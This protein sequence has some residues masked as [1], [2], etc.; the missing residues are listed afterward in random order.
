M[1]QIKVRLEYTFG[2]VDKLTYDGRMLVE[3][4]ESGGNGFPPGTR[5]NIFQIADGRLA[6]WADGETREALWFD[7]FE[8]MEDMRKHVPG[9]IFSAAKEQQVWS[10]AQEQKGR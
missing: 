7:V 2:R 4:M 5:F 8:N 6:A 1:G 9:N 10:T 3:K